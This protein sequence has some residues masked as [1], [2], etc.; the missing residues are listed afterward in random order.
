MAQ[1]EEERGLGGCHYL[2]VSVFP[3][4]TAAAGRRC[5]GPLPR[6]G[7]L[8]KVSTWHAVTSS[9]QDLGSKEKV[10]VLTA[11]KSHSPVGAGRLSLARASATAPM[12]GPRRREPAF[13]SLVYLGPPACV[14]SCLFLSQDA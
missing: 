10:A 12:C 11:A 1:R 13:P 8:F 14:L 6:R 9:K 7:P 5:L 3:T 4:G 2:R